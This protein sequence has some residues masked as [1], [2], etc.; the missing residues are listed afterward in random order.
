MR[1]VVTF[2]MKASAPTSRENLYKA[3]TVTSFE[4]LAKYI[5]RGVEARSNNE[6]TV[7]FTESDRN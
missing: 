1:N 7:R 2:L 6:N 5:L 3:N 4:K